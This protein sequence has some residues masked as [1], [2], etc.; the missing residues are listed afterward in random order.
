MTIKKKIK[1]WHQQ[2]RD[3]IK[4]RHLNSITYNERIHD[5][6]ISVQLPSTIYNLK[7]PKQ[8]CPDS[9]AINDE[10]I[11]ESMMN[12]GIEEEYKSQHEK[13]IITF[14]Q[15]VQK[16]NN[17]KT[18]EYKLELQSKN[19]K[20]PCPYVIMKD[21][22]LIDFVSGQDVTK[23]HLQEKGRLIYILDQ[24]SLKQFESLP[25]P[26]DIYSE[27]SNIMLARYVPSCISNEL[28][29]FW[30]DLEFLHNYF[31]AGWLKGCEADVTPHNTQYLRSVMKDGDITKAYGLNGNTKIISIKP[32]NIN[33][34]GGLVCEYM[35]KDGNTRTFQVS[36]FINRS[37]WTTNKL[38]SKVM[39]DHNKDALQDVLFKSLSLLS[40]L[41]MLYK[42]HSYDYLLNR[43][44]PAT[45]AKKLLT[46]VDITFS[47]LLV[48]DAESKLAVHKDIPSPLP[49]M[50]CGP[51]TYYVEENG[52]TKKYN[53]G[54]LVLVDGLL[55]L[56]YR[57]MD[58]I[59][60][61]GTTP[62][63]VTSLRRIGAIPKGTKSM[64]RFSIIMFSKFKRTKMRAYGNYIDTY[65]KQWTKEIDMLYEEYNQKQY[66]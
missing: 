53:G 24:R 50:V 42:K 9:A 59:I 64:S 3:D 65:Q 51:S 45:T 14:E 38:H 8:I 23:L 2:K 28:S 10:S 27:K 40:H 63:G 19:N 39:R 62:H 44:W 20:Q 21:S 34:P 17:I 1:N 30:F 41:E 7:I 66:Q 56:H 35:N 55:H 4:V 49:T 25:H 6:I 18:K 36:T 43:D 52:W 61:D 48:D 11:V 54:R 60:M 47:T 26:V 58:I 37:T 33:K 16:I 15:Y 57:P 32:R 13:K 5:S 46:M 12:D 29:Y 31:R 22:L